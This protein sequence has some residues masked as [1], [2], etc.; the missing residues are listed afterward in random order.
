MNR[1]KT[2]LKTVKTT[3]NRLSAKPSLGSALSYTQLLPANYRANLK[4]MIL[5]RSS[6]ARPIR[7]FHTTFA[8]N[9]ASESLETKN[10]DQDS[11]IHPELY[12]EQTGI[13]FSAAPFNYETL[14]HRIKTYVTTESDEY[15]PL[16]DL[17]TISLLHAIAVDYGSHASRVLGYSDSE[18]LRTQKELLETIYGSEKGLDRLILTPGTIRPV[19]L[20]LVNREWRTEELIKPGAKMG[21]WELKEKQKREAEAKTEDNAEK[22]SKSTDSVESNESELHTD[23]SNSSLQHADIISTSDIVILLLKAYNK[24]YSNAVIAKRAKSVAIQ[25]SSTSTLPAGS[26][27]PSYVPID[28]VMI[29]FRRTVY[30]GELDKSFEIIDASSASKNY[31]Q[32]VKENWRKWATRWGLGTSSVLLGVHGLLSSGLV[33]TWESTTGVLTMVFAYICNM[34]ILS[35]LAF[36]GRISGVGEYIRWIP[37]TSTTYWYSH[38]TEMKMASYIASIDQVLPENQ[39]EASFRVKKLLQNRKMMAIEVE[40]ETLMKEYWARGGEGFQ[41]VEPDQDPAEIFWRHKVEMTKAKRIEGQ[42]KYGNQYDMA[43]QVIHKMSLPHASTTDIPKAPE[44]P[45]PKGLPEL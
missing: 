25:Q 21:P 17:E 20:D 38:A 40:Q 16:T 24:K 36:A 5:S 3:L 43:D 30:G 22:I 14:S 26:A 19:F 41:W 37:G 28:I 4:N 12:S 8:R 29:P 2:G 32:S 42:K 11:N 18:I 31:M 39:N 23:S 45:A 7:Q 27:I 9:F 44:P 13:N 33:G 35:G 10:S 15:G 1:A 6:V 34:T